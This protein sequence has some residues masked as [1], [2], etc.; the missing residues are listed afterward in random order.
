M[1]KSQMLDAI[2]NA[3]MLHIEQMKKIKD[4]IDGK[5]VTDPTPLSKTECECGIWFYNNEEVMKNILGAQ[6]FER[7]DK[8]HENWHK[9]YLDIY[10]IFFKEEIKVS[11][12]SKVL[13]KGKFDAMTIDKAKLYF[14]QLQKSTEE[15][16]KVSES[17]LRRVA[18]LQ[19]TKF[20]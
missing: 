18:A 7:L 8:N 19:D 2:Q 16:L 9:D 17:A 4:V 6:L 12:F 11:L 20:K 13:G 14:A 10:N 3:K 1:N 15:L 5:S